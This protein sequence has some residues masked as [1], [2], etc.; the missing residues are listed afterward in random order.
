[1]ENRVP[2]LADRCRNN[3]PELSADDTTQNKRAMLGPILIFG[4][5]VAI[6]AT[7]LFIVHSFLRSAEEPA[8]VERERVLRE[9][10]EREHARKP[11]AS[12]RRQPQYAH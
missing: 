5:V 9:R 2:T 8:D 1:M 12:P 3:L 6:V 11:A 7:Y 10:A 4:L